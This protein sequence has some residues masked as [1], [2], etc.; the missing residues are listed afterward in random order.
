MGNDKP[1][2]GLPKAS[3]KQGD[4]LAGSAATP[5]KARLELQLPSRGS[6]P[7]QAAPLPA[8]VLLKLMKSK[9]LICRRERGRGMPARSYA[10]DQ[11]TP[12]QGDTVLQGTSAQPHH[13]VLLFIKHLS[14][15][16]DFHSHVRI[17][18]RYPA[19]VAPA[20]EKTPVLLVAPKYECDLVG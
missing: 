12:A 17:Q 2:A 6:H 8:A 18:V 14:L 15:K 10:R 7:H 11:A 20:Y 16:Q 5:T 1:R 13:I 19:S 3:T 9:L 4:A